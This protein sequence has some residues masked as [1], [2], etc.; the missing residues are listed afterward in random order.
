MDIATYDVISY[1]VQNHS[2][3]DELDGANGIFGK[4]YS[5]KNGGV[6]F[7][8][9]KLGSKYVSAVLKAEANLTSGRV[10]L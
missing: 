1:G 7:L 2:Y 8:V 10:K 6:D 5:L 9:P 3:L 4:E